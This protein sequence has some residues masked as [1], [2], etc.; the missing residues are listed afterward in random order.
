MHPVLVRR[1]VTA[2]ASALAEFAARTFADTFAGD[3]SLE[4][5]QAHLASSY[6]VRQQ[7]AELADPSV[8]TLLAHRDG[9]LVAYAQVRRKPPPPC[10]TQEQPVELHRFYVDRAAHGG[11]VASKLVL[12][13]HDAARELGGRHLW[14]G[15]WERNSRAIAFYS[16]S[17][18]VHVGSHDFFVGADRQ[19]DQVF[20]APVQ[21]PNSRAT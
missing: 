13:V 9:M 20:V 14:L 21:H 2:D 7:T 16:K 1:G 5:M 17:G 18:F 12:A 8:I 10:V 3:N 15:V 6:G 11:G 4:D 19:T